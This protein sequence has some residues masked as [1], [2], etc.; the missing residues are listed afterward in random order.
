MKKIIC[1]LFAVIMLSCIKEPDY[2]NTP[3]GN[4][5]ALWHLMDER[6][7][8]F[9]YKNINWD[10]IHNVYAKRIN[11]NM[12]EEQL[13][14]VLSKM[15]NELKD[16]HVNLYAS[17]DVSR[18]W[19][20]FE[21]YAPN[22]NDSIV[23]NNYLGTDYKIA[24]GIDYKVL[25]DNVGYMYYE[26]FADAVGEGNLDQIISKFSICNGIIIDVRNNGGGDLTNVNVI[27]SRFINER[28]LVGYISHKTGKGHDDFSPLFPKYLDATT[29]LRYQKPVIVLTN[30]QCYSAANDFISV[31]KQL[32]NVTIMGDRTGGGS[33]LPF[34]SELPNGWSIRFSASPMYDADKTQTEFGIDPD[35]NVQIKRSDTLKGLDTIIE[36][37][38]KLIA[39]KAKQS[40]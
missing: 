40:L 23:K 6:Y 18:Y 37:A 7:C 10:S 17:F 29:R 26:S 5:E 19:A 2:S 34:H 28:K 21:K 27:A 32:P 9:T 11:D 20:W 22:F 1:L 4:F 35:V 33:G 30:R 14:E 12:N 8:F 24:S 36:E 16:G 15:L 31:M 39:E 38:R 13:F 25:D 3:K